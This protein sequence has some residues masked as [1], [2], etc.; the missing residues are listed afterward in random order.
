MTEHHLRTLAEVDRFTIFDTETTGVDITGD[1]RIVT[2]FVGLM[3]RTGKIL[4]SKS[5]LID[6]GVEIPVEASNVHGI[7]TEVARAEGIS[8]VEG[9]AGIV[10][11][12]NARIEKGDPIVA[13]NIPFD[14]TIVDREARRHLGTT[15]SGVGEMLAIDPLIIDKN[16][17]KWRS[18]KRTLEVMSGHYGVELVGAHD[19]EADATATG[20]L[21]WAVLDKL[22]QR[23]TI[24]QLHNN[25]V[26]WAAAQAADFQEYLRGPKNKNGADPT[27]VIDGEWPFK[28]YRELVAA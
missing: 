23:T 19:A 25:Q 28:S 21:A 14:S 11:L 4:R 6:P 17:D 22:D 15:F 10:K 1:S 18:G 3:D 12:L 5:W 27:A 20:R 8:P 13:F 16:I 7:T 26:A 9:I 2:C 24:G